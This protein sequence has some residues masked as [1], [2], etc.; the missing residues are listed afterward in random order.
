MAVAVAGLVLAVGQV[1]V[2][3]GVGEAVADTGVCL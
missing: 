3:V 2:P 1:P